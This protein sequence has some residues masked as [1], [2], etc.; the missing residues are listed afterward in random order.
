M[1]MKTRLTIVLGFAARVFLPTDF[2]V[3]TRAVY[4]G[5]EGMTVTGV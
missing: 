1:L 5:P 4:L 2:P 3:C